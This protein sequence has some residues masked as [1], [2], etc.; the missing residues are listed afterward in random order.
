MYS[1]EYPNSFMKEEDLVISNTVMYVNKKLQ[2]ESSGHDWWH[3]YRV[4]KMALYIAVREGADRYVV[5][6]SAL[7][8]DLADWKLNNGNTEKGI[9]E[10]KDWLI[11]QKVN[12]KV[13]KHVCLII[14][15]ISFK[16]ANVY[17][18]IRTLEGKVVQDADRLDAIGAIGIARAFTYG[19][20]KGREMHNPD[21]KPI[22]HDSFEMYQQN[23]ATTI[24]HFHEK[25]LLLKEKMNTETA[26]KLAYERHHFMENFLEQFNCEWHGEK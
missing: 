21:K 12:E 6:L 13:V 20:Y 9:N 26:K 18:S 7:L 1:C 15:N 11:L 3:I 8:H 19:G 10:I 25:L 23:Q 4:W 24:N 5:Q 2:G 17:S 16:G 22:L 14:N